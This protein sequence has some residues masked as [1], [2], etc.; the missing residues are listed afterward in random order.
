MG[1]KRWDIG[2][3]YYPPPS[4]LLL[5]T[6]PLTTEVGCG[7]GIKGWSVRCSVRDGVWD[8]NVLAHTYT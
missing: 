4:N 3:S 8:E 7:V 1:S 6:P 2:Y 5:P